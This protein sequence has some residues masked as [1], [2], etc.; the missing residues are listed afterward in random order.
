[1]SEYLKYIPIFIPLLSGYMANAICPMKNSG[2]SGAIVHFRPP[3]EA[4][5]IIWPILYIL[6]GLAWY[7]T[8][9]NSSNKDRFTADIFF[10]SLVISLSIW[11]YIYN[12]KNLKKNAV[13][14]LGICIMFA[15][16]CYTS[17]TKLSKLM[18]CPL[19]TWLIIATLLNAVEVQEEGNKN[20]V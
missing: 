10:T 9:E 6:T 17:S 4:F 16:L 3:P 18:L 1:M 2:A 11:L 8:R 5:G 13:W 19:I 20:L 7:K 14:V 15:L 12:C